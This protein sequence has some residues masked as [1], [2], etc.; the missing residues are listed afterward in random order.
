M[1]LTVPFRH[2]I[3]A[4]EAN[5]SELRGTIVPLAGVDYPLSINRL[6]YVGSQLNIDLHDYW[7]RTSATRRPAE[8]VF[9]LP[10]D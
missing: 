8:L 6:R 5:W 2:P 10:P 4:P 3:K 1:V 9:D 7:D